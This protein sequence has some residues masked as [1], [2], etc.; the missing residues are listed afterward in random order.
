M[1]CSEL[2]NEIQEL[3]QKHEELYRNHANIVLFLQSKN[4]NFDQIPIFHFSK[5]K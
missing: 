1:K 5:N 2:Q 4:L 3:K